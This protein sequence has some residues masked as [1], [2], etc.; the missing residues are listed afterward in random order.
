MI[1]NEKFGIVYCGFVDTGGVWGE[2]GRKREEDD[3]KGKGRS[4]VAVCSIFPTYPAHTFHFMFSRL[5][6][7]STEEREGQHFTKQ[8]CLGILKFEYKQR[9]CMS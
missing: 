3:G 5:V 7:A 2:E 4:E 9:L 1:S 6:G 8:L